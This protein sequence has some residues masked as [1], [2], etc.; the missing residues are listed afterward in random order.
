MRDIFAIAIRNFSSSV[1][2][3]PREM[4]PV[5][6]PRVV[7]T[8]YSDPSIDTVCDDVRI[9]NRRPR[10]TAKRLAVQSPGFDVPDNV[11]HTLPH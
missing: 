8:V 5:A 10:V 2:L 4:P 9:R 1:F 6:V 11:L 7:A 3:H